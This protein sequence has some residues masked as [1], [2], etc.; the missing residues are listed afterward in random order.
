MLSNFISEV[1]FNFFYSGQEFVDSVE[2]FIGI[3]RDV[4]MFGISNIWAYV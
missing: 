2:P 1:I 4:E 3:I